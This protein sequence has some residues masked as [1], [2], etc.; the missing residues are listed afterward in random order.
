MVII[1]ES[2]FNGK[3]AIQLSSD[4]I[5]QALSFIF[6]YTEYFNTFFNHIGEEHLVVIFIVGLLAYLLHY[7]F[8]SIKQSLPKPRGKK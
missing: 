5:P 2:I 8:K 6:K 4:F 3:D 1:F 7:V